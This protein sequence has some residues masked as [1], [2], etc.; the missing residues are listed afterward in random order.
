MQRTFVVQHARSGIAAL[1]VIT[2]AVQERVRVV[3]ARSPGQMAEELRECLRRGQRPIAGWSFYSPDFAAAAEDL[4]EVKAQVTGVLHVAGGVHASAE[5]L[6]TLRAGF[7]LA[8]LGEG[9]TTAVRLLAEGEDPKSIPGIAWLEGDRLRS[10]GP[11]ERRPLDDFPGFNAPAGKWNALEITRGCVYAC[12]FCQTP[13]MFKARF[14]H[15]SVE[16]VRQHVRWMKRDGVRYLRFVTPTCLSYGSQDTS[17]NLAAV[18]ALLSAL[19]EE[20][21]EGSIYFGTFPSECRPEHLTP[22]SLRLL[23][24]YVDNRDL[25]IGGQSGSERLLQE[26]HRGHGVEE[27]VA[28]VR[29]SLEA[30]F[31]PDVDLLLGLP[32]ETDEDRAL[33]IQLGR[34]LVAL[35]ARLHSHSFMPLPGT[36]LRAGTPSPIDARTE[37]ELMRLESLGAA[38]GQWRSHQRIAGELVGL[39]ARRER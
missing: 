33:T 22:A 21:P 19:R 11:G 14:R 18:E 34:K 4:K 32:G 35:G 26:T 8:A 10:N 36:P 6:Q 15:R 3:F 28:A 16:N 24:R 38:H 1:N 29:H 12:S 17:V 23:R 31:R 25:V 2:A 20:L 9:E 13:F 30:G 39:R 7:D 5:P 27:I 37:R